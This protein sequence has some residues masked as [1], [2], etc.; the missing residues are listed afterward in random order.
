MTVTTFMQK[1]TVAG[2]GTKFLGRPG[3]LTEPIAILATALG[4]NL[5]PF[6]DQV[7]EMYVR[8]L[9]AGQTRQRIFQR[10]YKMIDMFM[11][12]KRVSTIYCR[13]KK[14]FDAKDPTSWPFIKTNLAAIVSFTVLDGLGA[15]I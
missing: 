7:L 5:Q 1:L 14:N 11:T 4:K 10:S 3:G 6:A 13:V 9:A 2:L 8:Y 15:C 12:K